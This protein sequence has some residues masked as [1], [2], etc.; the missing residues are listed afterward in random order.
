MLIVTH[1]ELV[2]P[3]EERGRELVT[4]I[5]MQK[6]GPRE[7]FIWGD[8]KKVFID[9]RGIQQIHLLQIKVQ[10]QV[11]VKSTNTVQAAVFVTWFNE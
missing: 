4:F 1:W 5:N 9:E 2:S 3:Q 11:K 6:E 10:R 8:G 7:S